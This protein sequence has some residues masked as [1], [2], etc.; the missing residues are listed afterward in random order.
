MT[1]KNLFESP[2]A[3]RVGTILPRDYQRTDVAESFRLWD[4]GC[5]GVLTRLATGL[6]KTIATALK[7]RKW[8]DR[9]PNHRCMVLSYEQQLVWQFAEEIEDVLGITPGIEMGSEE[10][11]PG[12]LPLIT[13]ASRQSLMRHELA[14]AGQLQNLEMLGVAT[15]GLIIPKRTAERILKVLMAGSESAEAAQAALQALQSDYRV[16]RETT[17]FSRLHKFD[18]RYDWLIAFDEAHKY[19]MRHTTTTGHIVEWFERNP[20]SRRSGLTATPKRSDNVSIGDRLFPGVAIDY[21]YRK[22]VKEGYA[23]PFVQKYIVV[24]K[25]DFKELKQLSKSQEDWDARLARILEGQLAELCQPTLDLVGTRKTLIFSPSVDM[26]KNVVAYINARVRCECNCGTVAWYPRVEIGD[27]ARCRSCSNFLEN[28]NVLYAG[29]SARCVWGE[30]PPKERKAIYTAH[31]QGEFQFLSVCGL[32]REGYNDRDIACVAVFRP[33]SKEA[34]SLAEQMKGRGGRPL[35]GCI[36]GMESRD[37]RLAAISNSH[38]P[39]C[40]V[41]DLVGITGLED[42]ATTVQI[43]ADGIADE[44]VE[45]AEDIVLEDPD[46]D[47]EDAIEEATRRDAERKEQARLA[48]EADRLKRQQE[49]E[50]RSRMRAEVEYTVHDRGAGKKSPNDATEKQLKYLAF[51][52][53]KIIGMIPSRKLAG[54]AISLLKEG[55]TCEEAAYLCGLDSDEWE[56]TRCTIKQKRALA[57]RGINAEGLTPQQASALFDQQKRSEYQASNPS[58]FFDALE[59]IRSCQTHEDLDNVARSLKNSRANLSA[60]DWAE[61]KKAGANHRSSICPF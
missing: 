41:I 32:C 18:W 56:P 2:E 24:E 19:S 28:S 21:S 35:K 44:I 53:M 34:S 60:E 55:K 9:S 47:I 26:A 6:G 8:L 10:I 1:Q 43:Y 57:R 27:G 25:L 45:E 40:L 42:S 48:E 15:G 31:Q 7:F 11:E 30:L 13:V 12:K 22:A 46:I 23:V 3:M 38:K 50:E 14:D 51:L 61:I 39:N 37:Q 16:D 36:D 58:A 59:K 49:A 33:V 4:E 54:R 17:A 5:R 20:N 29:L 52:G